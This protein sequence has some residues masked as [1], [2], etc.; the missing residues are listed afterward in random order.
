M[1]FSLSLF[2]FEIYPQTYLNLYMNSKSDIIIC[3]CGITLIPSKNIKCKSKKKK[4]ITKTKKKSSDRER[5][6]YKYPNKNSW[7]IISIKNADGFLLKYHINIHVI[8]TW[9]CNKNYFFG[10]FIYKYINFFFVLSSSFLFILL[11]NI[12]TNS[13]RTSHFNWTFFIFFLLP[14][15]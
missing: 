5:E 15:S 8:K 10:I 4:N 13:N 11:I 2:F 14:Y 6:K 7:N 12:S 1:Y 9:K 3:T